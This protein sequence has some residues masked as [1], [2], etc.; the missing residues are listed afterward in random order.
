MT[1][2]SFLVLAAATALCACGPSKDVLDDMDS[3]TP[4]GDDG[5]PPIETDGGVDSGVTPDAGPEP[6]GG[7]LP[8]S[9]TDEWT[10]PADPAVGHWDEAFSMPGVGGTAPSDALALAKGPDGSIYIGGQF[11]HAGST[12]ANNVVKYTSAAGWETLG[13]GIDGTVWSLALHPAGMPIYAAAE[14]HGSSETAILSFDGSTWTEL[15]RVDGLIHDMAVG[16]DGKVYIGGFFEGIGGDA[17]IS[18]FAVWDG[19]NWSRLGDGSPDTDVSAVIVDE[20]GVCIGG[21]FSTV[22]TTAAQNVACWDG[23]AWT[24]YDFADPFYEVKVLARDPSGVLVAGGHF[25]GDD[26]GSIARWTGTAWETIGGGLHGP[27]GPAY[28][29]GIA[30]V[31]TD[32]YVAGYIAAAG[33]TAT[34]VPVHDVA[35]WDGSAWHDVGGG[36]H[37][38][39]GI[40]IMIQNVRRM[41][42]VDSLVYISG[43]FT[44]VGTQSASHVAVWDGT[45]WSALRGPG[46]LD[47]GINGTVN[48]IAARGDCGVYI[49]GTFNYA[50]NIVANNVAHFDG[51]KWN[52][53][54][55]GLEG[56]INDLAV[57]PDGTLYAGGDFIGP[58]FY[59]LAKW[60][61]TAWSAVGGNVMQPVTALAVDDDGNLYVSGDFEVAGD[62]RANRI[63][64]FDGSAWHAFG[65][66]LDRPA[67]TIEITPEGEVIVGGEFESAGGAPAARIARW[68]GSS[69]SSY[70]DGLPGWGRVSDIAFYRGQ[71]VVAGE[72]DALADGGK[73]VAVWDGTTWS[74]VGGGLFSRY[75]SG[76]PSVFGLAAVGDHLFAV[77]TFALIPPD[78]DP[79]TPDAPNVNAAYFDG[80]SWTGLGAGLNDSSE[81]IL[82]TEAG[83]W[84]GGAFTKADTTP[85]VAIALWRFGH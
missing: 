82:A 76:S 37:R 69:W 32:M 23:T 10:P 84:F 52:P 62:V 42:A 71:L 44:A 68:D 54:G 57:A 72:W 4:P 79:E 19:S 11:S 51:S 85:S 27:L 22:G 12:P 29:E 55:N 35:R 16:A 56:S 15:T 67:S 26:G 75:E 45:Y 20:S 28:V 7:P 34:A 6:D 61:G 8:P 40:G 60:D 39:M 63:A 3:G 25:P 53:L 65:E 83:V 31:G 14:M 38:E 1:L 74:S 41:V 13:D 46:Q 9:C 48:V 30:F 58:G 49:G 73:G 64:M 59:Y 24:G 36:A 5:G 17:T 43:M 78:D 18:S 77:G 2:R 80:T 47:G 66:G 50:G 33:P 81:A 70:G 21:R